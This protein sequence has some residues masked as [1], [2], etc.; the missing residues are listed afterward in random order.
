MMLFRWLFLG[1]I[2]LV[3]AGCATP[4]PQP[5]RLTRPFR[6]EQDTMA[7][8][9]ELVWEY[10]ID[11]ASGKATAHRREP[12]PEYALHCFVLARSVRQFIDHACFDPALPKVDQV[13][14]RQLIRQVVRRNP[15][16]I[17]EESER[18]VIPGYASLR[19]FSQS[20]ESMLKVECGG[21]WQSY[22]QRGNWRMIF[23]FPR[24]HQRQTAERLRNA[25]KQNRFP[26]IHL[27]R[28]PALTINHAMLVFDCSDEAG[29]FRFATYDPND[30]A[31]PAVLHFDRDSQ[32]FSLLRNKYFA[33]GRVNVYEIYCAAH[34]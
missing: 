3:L 28:F 34:Y 12:K 23:P 1:L 26:I 29:Q 32:S 31:A 33:G 6:F 13:T 18:V 20:H 2:S 27:V 9:N 15:R 25:L 21:A 19:E 5:A 11:P 7:Y 22:F 24:R 30:P 14:Y 16:K 17:S 8:A 10:I 4:E